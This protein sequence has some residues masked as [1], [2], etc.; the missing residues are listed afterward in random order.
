MSLVHGIDVKTR[1][2]RNTRSKK[3]SESTWKWRA[4]IVRHESGLHLKIPLY[5]LSWTT[6]NPLDRGNSISLSSVSLTVCA[7]KTLRPNTKDQLHPSSSCRREEL[8]DTFF[9]FHSG[10][11][12]KDLIQVTFQSIHKVHLGKP[13]F[14]D[15][16]TTDGT[17][18]EKK[19]RFIWWWESSNEP[20]GSWLKEWLGM[21]T[22]ELTSSILC[23]RLGLTMASHI[24]MKEVLK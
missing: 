8:Y 14:A 18:E 6:H 2:W 4:P 9:F 13:I 10:Y 5:W 3:C 15:C 21:S 22:Y 7:S 1:K 20:K 17:G 23:S 24:D 16:Q 12:K 11:V 19:W